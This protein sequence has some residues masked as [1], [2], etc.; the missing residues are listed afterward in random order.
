ML[1]EASERRS[2][3]INRSYFFTN[4]HTGGRLDKVIC[5]GNFAPKNAMK[6]C[7]IKSLNQAL[8]EYKK[9]YLV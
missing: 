3:T 8:D 2:E 4:T 7:I 5:G 6:Y 9:V 1:R